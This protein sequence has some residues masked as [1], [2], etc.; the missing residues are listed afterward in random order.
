MKFSISGLMRFIYLFSCIKN[1]L[2]NYIVSWLSGSMVS[3]DW[4]DIKIMN[5][6]SIQ[7]GSNF[8]AGRG[9][10]LESVNGLG[11]IIIGANV[12]F[13]DYVHVGSTNRIRICD[14]VLLG[15]KVLLSDHSHGTINSFTEPYV[16]LAPNM[17]P[18]VSKGP[19]VI[20]ARVWL[21]DGVCVLAGVTIGEGAVVGANSV[22]V[23]DVPPRTVW[24]GVPA[25][26]IWPKE[27]EL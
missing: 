20:G 9:V 27:Q 22:V 13:S 16:N 4:R 7:I 5:P 3:I 8:S 25:R 2:L 11:K 23:R 21:G 12:N 10:W 19:I 15:S 1:R 14:G 17:R 24:A 6:D 18:L 26:Q